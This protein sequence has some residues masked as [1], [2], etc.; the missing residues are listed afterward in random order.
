MLVLE[1]PLLELV[2]QTEV[3]S[4]LLALTLGLISVRSVV[5]VV[6]RHSVLTNR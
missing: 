4:V 3:V 2:N 6:D 1:P 5:E